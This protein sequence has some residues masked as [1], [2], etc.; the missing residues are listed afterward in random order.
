MVC[1]NCGK[2]IP[3]VGNVCPYCKVDKRQDQS[4]FLAGCLGAVVG[5]VVGAMVAGIGG[6]IAGFFIGTILALIAAGAG[7]P[8]P[9]PRQVAPPSPQQE[10]ALVD[11]GLHKKC[12]YCAEVIKQEAIKCRYCGSDLSGTKS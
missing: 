4:E 11:T 1:S 2:E 3:F 12:P 8:K 10:N 6:G 7:K 9:A 5:I